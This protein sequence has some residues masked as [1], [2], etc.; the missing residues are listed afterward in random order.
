MLVAGAF[1]LGIGVVLLL[2]AC[3][4]PPAF[5]VSAPMTAASTPAPPAPPRSVTSVP[6]DPATP[7]AVAAGPFT[8]THLSVP[9]FGVTAV[10]DPV[11][12][13]AGVLAPPDDPATGKL[14][15]RPGRL[16]ELLGLE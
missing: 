12:T 6:R 14:G 7:P 5:S 3:R 4:L 1:V 8:P 11:F 2:T 15:L 16:R 9:G 10:V 13:T